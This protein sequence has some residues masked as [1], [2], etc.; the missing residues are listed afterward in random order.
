MTDERK[1]AGVTALEGAEAAA[2]QT[3]T[4]EADAAAPPQA[5][6]RQRGTFESFQHRDFTL[7]WLGALVS[8]IVLDT[9]GSMAELSLIWTRPRACISC[10]RPA[11]QM[12]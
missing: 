1:P 7:F 3:L 10:C 4:L 12:A 11:S 5:V 2:E 9:S 6:G 8:N